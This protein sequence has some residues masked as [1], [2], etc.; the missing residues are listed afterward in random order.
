MQ[1]VRKE[2]KKEE[3]GLTR[4]E[5]SDLEGWGMK[6]VRKRVKKRREDSPEMK[7]VRRRE[8]E[9]RGDSPEMKRVILR[10]GGSRG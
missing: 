5:K 10:A 1:R 6:K 3:G 2:S 7:R 9:R 8:R 4:D